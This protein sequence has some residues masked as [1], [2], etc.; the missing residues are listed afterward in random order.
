M[1]L[2]DRPRAEDPRHLGPEKPGRALQ[3]LEGA[4]PLG[5]VTRKRHQDARVPQV[6]GYPHVGDREEPDPRV[7]HL[8][9]YERVGDGLA[10]GRGDLV[11]APRGLSPRSHRYTVAVSRMR[12]PS[13]SSIRRSAARKV[14][15]TTSRALPTAAHAIS[16]RCHRSW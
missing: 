16:A 2:R 10:N 4:L 8:T 3:A 12:T 11:R 6:V 13:A 9:A 15:S 14:P 5:L 7:A 1:K